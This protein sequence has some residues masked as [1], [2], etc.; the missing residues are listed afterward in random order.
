MLHFSWWNRLACSNGRKW[1]RK[2][3]LSISRHARSCASTV[4]ASARTIS[5]C[6]HCSSRRAA[7]SQRSWRSE[8]R[9]QGVGDLPHLAASG[10]TSIPVDKDTAKALYRTAGYRVCGDRAVRVDILERLADLIRPALS[11][12]ER[13][14]RSEAR[15]I[16]R[17]TQLCDY[18]RHD[19]SHG[20]FRR[21]FRFNSALARL[22]HGSQA[23]AGRGGPVSRSCRYMMLPARGA[24]TVPTNDAADASRKRQRQERQTQSP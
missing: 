22:S 5:T 11:W 4:C 21:G 19:V 10:R 14:A 12:R 20:R 15:R 17:R 7:R 6:R 8:A 13:F 16:F 2:S 3:K 1:P 9:S 23:Q 18:R 24:A